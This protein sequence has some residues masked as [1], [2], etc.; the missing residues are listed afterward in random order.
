MLDALPTTV[1]NRLQ[2]S[3]C[4]LFSLSLF[5][6]TVSSNAHSGF[7]PAEIGSM[8]SLKCFFASANPFFPAVIPA[9]LQTL[10][11]LEEIGLKSTNRLGAIPT[12][13]GYLT[14]L[15]LLDLDDNTLFGPVPTE[16]GRLANMEFLL[17]NR[18]SLTGEIPV[19]LAALTNLR[20][21]FF[22]RNSFNGTL[23]PMCA[24]GIFN[25]T[26]GNVDETELITSD[27]LGPNSEVECSCCTSCCNDQVDGCHDYF[28][29][30]NLD[31]IWENR[32][33]R[34]TYSFG[35][36][37]RFFSSTFILP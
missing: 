20:L 9:F 18:N 21:A 27:C 14:D 28:E 26:G 22:D 34:L 17:L 37:T 25:E 24:L 8:S 11:K 33:D 12:F 1:G 32:N 36:N 35:G 4:F 5:K 30:P 7:L 23:A 3:R 29:V 31:P 19:E 16:L 2:S 10:T 6:H 13:L 15:V